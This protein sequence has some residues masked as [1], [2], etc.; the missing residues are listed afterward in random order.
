M[1]RQL[2]FFL[3]LFSVISS[4]L[5]AKWCYN[6]QSTTCGPDHWSDNCKG[7]NQSP[8]N[9]EQ[10][11]TSRNN[12]LG[13]FVFQGYDKAPPEKWVFLNNGHAV[14][15]TIGENGLPS[16][17]INISGAGLPGVY[18]A[19]QFHFHWGSKNE[20]GSEH[21]IDWHQYPMELHIVHVNLKYQTVADALNDKNGIAVLGFMYKVTKVDNQN[22][23]TVVDA[24]KNISYK[25]QELPLVTTFRLDSLLPSRSLLSKYFRYEGS[26][27]TPG[28]GEAVIWTVFQDPIEISETQYHEFVDTIHFSQLGEAAQKMLN[29]FRP[30]QPLNKRKVYASKD[31]IINQSPVPSNLSLVTLFTT[32]MLCWLL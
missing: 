9:I 19:V 5:T 16:K 28:C 10:T 4:V 15:L 13:D 31:A 12:N 7:E 26:L 32:I 18:R 30:P 24:L 22:Y 29:N 20:N 3:T 27:T 6:S 11:K 14:Q 2:M 21:T 1:M 8:I 23:N 25:G 17:N